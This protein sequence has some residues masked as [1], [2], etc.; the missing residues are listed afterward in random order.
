MKGILSYLY[1][2]Y[3]SLFLHTGSNISKAASYENDIEKYSSFTISSASHTASLDIC[4]A[5]ESFIKKNILLKDI[6]IVC[7]GTDRATG[8]SLGPIIGHKLKEIIHDTPLVVGTLKSPVHGKNLHQ[9]SDYING[10]YP[11]RYIIAVDAC[12]GSFNSI[13]N[14]YVERGPL[15]PGSALNKNLS[16]IG[17]V[18]ITAVVNSLNGNSFSTLQNTRLFTIITIA[19]IICNGILK[20]IVSRETYQNKDE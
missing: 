7:I 18:S 1:K 11:N 17:D 20:F 5:L 3:L 16:P 10:L 6:I 2:H 15:Y 14:I 8:D 12:L 4:N 13:G 19:E 9:V